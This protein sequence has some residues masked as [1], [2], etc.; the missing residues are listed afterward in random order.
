MSALGRVGAIFRGIWRSLIVWG[1]SAGVTA[2][3][4]F[5][6]AMFAQ[7]AISADSAGLPAG[8][9]GGTIA[10]YVWGKYFGR[11]DY[12]RHKKMMESLGVEVI[13]NK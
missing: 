1:S 8:Y 5:G 2:A 11:R 6:V 9:I 7:G 10:G 12:D 4:I 3:I 13:D